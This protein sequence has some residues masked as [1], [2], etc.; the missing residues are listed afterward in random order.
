LAKSA[1]T[2]DTSASVTPP[3]GS[4]ALIDA[5]T[6]SKAA[7]EAETGAA[8]GSDPVAAVEQP[9]TS[10]FEKPVGIS[11]AETDADTASEPAQFAP[12]AEKDENSTASNEGSKC[13]KFIP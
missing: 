6:S 4:L 13:K 12:K 2:E 5:Q 1:T 3:T 9:V 7:P 8:T 11:V 10:E